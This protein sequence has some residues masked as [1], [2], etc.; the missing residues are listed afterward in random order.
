MF[1]YVPCFTHFEN[2]VPQTNIPKNENKWQMPKKKK[3]QLKSKLYL[4]L[5]NFKYLWYPEKCLKT[6]WRCLFLKVIRVHLKN[7][8]NHR[9]ENDLL[10]DSW[11]TKF[12]ANFFRRSCN[13]LITERLG[14]VNSSLLYG[15][16]NQKANSKA[17][18]LQPKFYSNWTGAWR[19]AR[20]LTLPLP[21]LSNVCQTYNMILS[22]RNW[23]LLKHYPFLSIS[24][25]PH[26]LF[27]R[28]SN[29]REHCKEKFSVAHPQYLEH[30]LTFKTLSKEAEL[31]H[32]ILHM[33]KL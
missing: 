22:L 12:S 13:S 29:A 9:S 7:I 19:R 6:Q 25:S 30:R 33:F 2:S 23:W 3:D 8:W 32:T 20:I 11:S 1:S 28:S 16:T 18:K 21:V 27:A 24:F 31:R 14:K 10:A 4:K 5:N 15:F 26:N 17:M